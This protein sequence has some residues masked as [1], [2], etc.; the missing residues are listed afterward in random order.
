[1]KFID[2]VGVI[3]LILETQVL[4]ILR[5]G[6]L[7]PSIPQ[8]GTICQLRSHVNKA[9]CSLDF[10]YLKLLFETDFYF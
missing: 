5:D 10:S 9:A 2:G 4:R 1:M 8:T 6:C 7:I 3:E